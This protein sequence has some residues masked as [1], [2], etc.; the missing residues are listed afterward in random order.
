MEAQQVNNRMTGQDLDDLEALLSKALGDEVMAGRNVPT[1][2][3]K[4]KTR[5]GTYLA[6]GLQAVQAEQEAREEVRQG[7]RDYA[8]VADELSEPSMTL[9]DLDATFVKLAQ[10]AA[11]EHGLSW[12]PTLAWEDEVRDAKGRLDRLERF[13]V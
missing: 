13:G 1:L 5:Y 7:L 6:H 3:G 8:D 12:P 2:R 4:G 10:D 9:A 11:K